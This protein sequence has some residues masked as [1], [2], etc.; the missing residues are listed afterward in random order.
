MLDILY[1]KNKFLFMSEFKLGIESLL[2][3]QF[4]FLS[5]D[6]RKFLIFVQGV[7]LF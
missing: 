7:F 4:L 5:Q 3:L 1:V 2:G 6:V